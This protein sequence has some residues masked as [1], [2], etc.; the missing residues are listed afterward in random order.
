MKRA[1]EGKRI[2]KRRKGGQYVK[3]YLCEHT[4]IQV[5][6]GIRNH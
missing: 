6:M 2:N 1:S 5:I 4:Y 3:T